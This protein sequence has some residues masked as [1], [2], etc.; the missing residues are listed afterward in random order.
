MRALITFFCN[1][2]LYILVQSVN[3]ALSP[4]LLYIYVGGLYVVFAALYLN[5]FAGLFAVAL[6]GLIIDAPLN[7]PFG[8]SMLLF[9]IAFV[10]IRWFRQR[11]GSHISSILFLLIQ[12]TNCLLFL[13]LSLVQAWV[14]P[15]NFD[16]WHGVLINLALSQV[17]LAI[18]QKWFFDLQYLG[19]RIFKLSGLKSSQLS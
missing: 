13:A 18:I 1:L 2:L 7:C 14:Q 6:T 10:I 9:L 4:T 17:I 8:T 19:W 3:D 12:A 5:A 15:T 16:Y 11:L